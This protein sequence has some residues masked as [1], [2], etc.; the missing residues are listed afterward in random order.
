MPKLGLGGGVNEYATAAADDGS[1]VD[2]DRLRL[3]KPPTILD[4]VL[5]VE[6]KRPLEF[7]CCSDVD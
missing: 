7:G 1:S 5:V 3:V 4:M 6:G 2:D